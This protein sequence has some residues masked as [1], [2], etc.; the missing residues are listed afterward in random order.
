VAVSIRTSH[1]WTKNESV[2]IPDW[3]IVDKWKSNVALISSVNVRLLIQINGWVIPCFR[4]S[5]I[6]DA[7]TS[8]DLLKA[9]VFDPVVN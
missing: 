2:G 1:P 6:S 5:A 7:K 3:L 9:E 4:I 8:F